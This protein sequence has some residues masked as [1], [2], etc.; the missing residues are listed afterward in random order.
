MIIIYRVRNN[1]THGS[2]EMSGDDYEIMENSIPILEVFV[3]LIY[4]RVFGEKLE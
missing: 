2:K 1:L 4:T 3:K